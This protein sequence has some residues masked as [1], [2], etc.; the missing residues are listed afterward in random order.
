MTDAEGVQ[1]G[2]EYTECS[3]VAPFARTLLSLSTSEVGRL[4]ITVV[5]SEGPIHTEE[6]ARRIREAFGLQKTG[7]RILNHVREALLAEAR[8]GMISRQKEFW[9]IPGR[10][11]QEVRSRRAATVQLRRAAMIAPEEYHLAILRIIE[12][13]VAISF[14]DLGVETARRF[15][16]DR[17]GPELKQEIS[18]R[19]SELVKLRKIIHD[20]SKLRIASC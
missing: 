3:L 8:T 11:I 4:A 15:G 7:N 13:A 14:E 9:T 16:F 18:V 2:T 1:N 10:H 20:G 6:V 17:T 19:I 12:E 5:E